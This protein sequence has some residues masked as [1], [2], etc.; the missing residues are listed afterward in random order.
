MNTLHEENEQLKIQLQNTSDQRDEFHRGARENAN[1]VGK[2]QKE[3]EQLKMKKDNLIKISA[4][5]QVRNDKLSKE[6]KELKTF[7]D[8]V[9]EVIDNHILEE[10]D[11]R[12]ECIEKGSH[13]SANISRNIIDTLKLKKRLIFE[14]G[15]I[16]F[17]ELLN[18]NSLYLAYVTAIM[19]KELKGDVE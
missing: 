11:L 13:Y 1:R 7:K 3:N 10:T 4:M 14:M 15:A 2:L 18:E 6:N 16:E 12:K 5:T 8:K 19:N 9:F 17:I